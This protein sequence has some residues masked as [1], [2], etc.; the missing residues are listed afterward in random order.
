MSLLLKFVSQ[1]IKP[2]LGDLKITFDR[3][4][5]M[6]KIVQKGQEIELTFDQA[7]TE[8]EKLFNDG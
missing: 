2:M 4:A 1:T 5:R 3:E 6:V 7:I 8:I